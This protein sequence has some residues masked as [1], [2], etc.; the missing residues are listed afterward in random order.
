[1][2]PKPEAKT[3]SFISWLH[4]LFAVGASKDSQTKLFRAE[5]HFILGGLPGGSE[6]YAESLPAPPEERGRFWLLSPCD[7]YTIEKT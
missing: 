7:C 2:H 1:M 6:K 5:A 4:S 3:V